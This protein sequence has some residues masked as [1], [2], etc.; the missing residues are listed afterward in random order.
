M[1]MIGDK[2]AP[3]KMYRDISFSA[4]IS[5]GGRVYFEALSGSGNRS[6]ACFN[7]SS[8]ELSKE[9]EMDNDPESYFEN[10]HALFTHPPLTDGKRLFVSDRYGKQIY[11]YDIEDGYS[12]ER[13]LPQNDVRY[14]FAP[15]LSI[16]VNNRIYSP[17]SYGLTT[18]DLA[19]NYAAGHQSLAMGM[20]TAP[21]PI[22]RPIRYGDKL[23]IFC[24][25]RLLCL[26]C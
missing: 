1:N 6:L 19:Q 11:I 21:K 5:L 26:D 25:D 4:P 10:R 17:T 16:V 24:E 2:V 22:A 13:N 3:P 20:S 12:S 14:M 8:G 23:F 15:H 18:L 9:M 7:P